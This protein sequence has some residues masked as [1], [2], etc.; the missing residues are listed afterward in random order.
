M[1]TESQKLD[2]ARAQSRSAAENGKDIHNEVRAIVI[3]ALVEHQLDK[4]SVKRVIEAVFEGVTEGAPKSTK[5]LKDIMMEA[6]DGLDEGLST[7]AEAS[8]LAIEEATGR[9]DEFSEKDVKQAWEDL[10]DLEGLFVSGLKDLAKAGTSATKGMLGDMVTHIERTGTATGK[11]VSDALE[12]LGKSTAKVHRPSIADIEKAS[13]ASV[14]TIASI[15]A[16]FLEGIADSARH[17]KP[18]ADDEA[19]KKE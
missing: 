6:A 9:I 10:K 13:R 1:T 16:G 11:T 4:D 2:K 17:E 15:A 12:T 8:K 7:A 3:D 18:P 14:A 19:D 5:D